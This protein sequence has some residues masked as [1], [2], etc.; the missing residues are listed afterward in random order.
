MMKK[1][2]IRGLLTKG[3]LSEIDVH[4]AKF[5]TGFSGNKDADIFLAAAMLSHATGSGDICLDLAK[6]AGKSLMGKQDRHDPLKC[7]DLEPW[8]EKLTASPA[9]GRPGDMR[10]LILDTHNRL[11]LYRYWDYERTLS[12]SILNRI[13]KDMQNLNFEQLKE[14]LDRLFPKKNGQRINWQKIAA[15]VLDR[16][17][18]K[19]NGQRIN[20]Q[21]IAAAVASLKYFSVITGGPGTG[22]TFT[23]T[24]F[25]ALLLEQDPKRP[26]QIYL[27]APTGKAA[28]RLKQSIAQTK[29]QMKCRDSIKAAIPSEVYTLHRMLKPIKDSPYFHYNLDN[30]LIADVVVVDEASMVDLALMAKLLQA[31][32]LNARLILIGDKDQLASVEAG[33]VLGDICDRDVMHGFSGPFI[34]RLTGLT[35]ENVAEVV[36][37]AGPASRLQD[38]IVVLRKSYRFDAGSGIGALSHAVNRGS[39]D[40]AFALLNDAGEKSIN[41]QETQAA[42]GVFETLSRQI[43]EGYQP[44]LKDNDPSE[45]LQQLTRFKILCALNVGPFGVAAINRL[46]ERVLSRQNL[47]QPDPSGEDPWYPGRPVLITRNNYQL[48]LFNGDIGITMADSASAANQLVV[49]FPGNSGEV[50]RFQPYQLPEHETVYAMTVHKSQGSEFDEVL[51]ILPDKDFPILTRELLYTALTRARVKISIWGQRSIFHSAVDRTIERTSGLRDALWGWQRTEVREQKAEDRGLKSEG[52]GK[53]QKAEI[54]K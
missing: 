20:W 51:F 42:E 4:F 44:Y 9:V 26:L 24:Q 12:D 23:V 40:T 38:S 22:K 48:G 3:L 32:P 39:A 46:A 33:S 21:K 11:Y 13:R 18:P 27:T 41:W 37:P 15:A 36:Q 2:V 43:V 5:I 16:L 30:P 28:A 47:I 53:G 10:P 50:R 8:I 25:L 54:K 1:A 29:D 14:S 31:I 7:P 49:F 6:T 52:R 35:G 19:K 34:E 45:A 17:F